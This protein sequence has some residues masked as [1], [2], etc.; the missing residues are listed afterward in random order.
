MKALI[1]S[2][3]HANLTA[4]D[5][6]IKEAGSFDAFWCLGDLVGYGPD[7][8]DCIQ[9]VR[10]MPNATCLL[11]NHDAA[12]LGRIEVESFNYEARNSLEWLHGVITKENFDFLKNLHEVEV[13]EDVT[14]VHGSPRN[15]VW[16]YILDVKSARRNFSF[17]ETRICMFGH[18]HVPSIFR[19]GGNDTVELLYPDPGVTFSMQHRAL[20]NP[21]SVG[22]PR[23][24]DP[25]AAY[26]LFDTET[27]VFTFDRAAYHFQEVQERIMSAGLPLRHALR[28]AEGY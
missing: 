25:R 16:E 1:V 19:L 2:D 7:P 10:E 27:R 28:L 12:I 9:R 13:V 6:V 18:S 21:G 14:L 23:D 22:Q 20:I 24:H 4:L 8:N 11:G 3:I 26:M 15:P 17:F 5:A